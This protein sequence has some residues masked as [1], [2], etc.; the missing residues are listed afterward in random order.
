MSSK[1]GL[2]E[3]ARLETAAGLRGPGRCNYCPQNETPAGS[4]LA[5]AM[6]LGRD[7]ATVRGALLRTTRPRRSRGRQHSSTLLGGEP[8]CLIRA[9][10]QLPQAGSAKH[11]LPILHFPRFPLVVFPPEARHKL[12]GAHTSPPQETAGARRPSHRGKQ[13][14]AEPEDR[15]RI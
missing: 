7:Q 12:S 8:E 5:R 4:A 13:P 14:Y 15:L 11:D 1:A 2:E 3:P 6:L 10:S 9:H